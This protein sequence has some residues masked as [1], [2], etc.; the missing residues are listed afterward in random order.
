M[1]VVGTKGFLLKFIKTIAHFESPYIGAP[2]EKWF[3]QAQE[4]ASVTKS[5]LNALLC[6]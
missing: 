4:V 1:R 6:F 5:M 3:V 2:H